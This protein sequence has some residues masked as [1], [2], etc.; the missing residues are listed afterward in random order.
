MTDPGQELF[1]IA[2]KHFGLPQRWEDLSNR[3]QLDWRNIAREF[4]EDN[5]WDW[6]YNTGKY[7]GK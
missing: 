1:K 4:L 3:K 5:A 6:V 2:K 7:K